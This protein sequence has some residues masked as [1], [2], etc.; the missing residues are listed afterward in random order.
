MI[1]A[2]IFDLDGTLYDYDQ[3]DT[4]GFAT[5]TAFMKQQFGME[6]ADFRRAFSGAVNEVATI[7]DTSC[8]ALH[9][10]Y[11]RFHLLLEKAGLPIIP[12]A[13]NMTQAYWSGFMANLVPMPGLR[14]T[15]L[16][17]KEKGLILG[18]GTNMMVDYQL[19]KM[20]K[21][22]C[23]ELFDFLVTS[24]E[25]GSEKP[26]QPLFWRCAAKAS[27][28]ARECLFVGDSYHHDVVG[29]VN[30]GMQ[31]VWLQPDDEKAKAHPE[32]TRI[33]SLPELVQLL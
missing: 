9:D 17:L 28:A 26:M 15:L 19:K 11:L 29:A 1:K 32:V 22:D 2:V 27:C 7:L 4:A 30:A 3:A 8:A 12:H 21:L 33:R 16:L 25:A 13:W 31:A 10:R 14:E 20:E 6:E 5:L 24:E 18:I 23:A